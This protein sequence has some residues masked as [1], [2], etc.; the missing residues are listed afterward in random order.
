MKK[1]FSAVLSRYILTVGNLDVDIGTVFQMVYFNTKNP[2]FGIH[3]KALEYKLKK[4]VARGGERTRVLLI[5][6][7]FSFFTTLPLSHS[8]S[9]W[10]I[11]YLVDF[12]AMLYNYCLLVFYFC[13][14]VHFVVIWFIFPRF[15]MLYKE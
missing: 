14:L 1:T 15:G 4:E 3:W 9:P 8:G 13:R 11:K 10:S 6:F 5:S 12:T 2:N 7:I